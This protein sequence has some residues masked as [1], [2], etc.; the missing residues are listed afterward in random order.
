MRLLRVLQFG[1]ILFLATLVVSPHSCVAVGGSN[2]AG[3]S[4]RASGDRQVWNPP[5]HPLTIEDYYQHLDSRRIASLTGTFTQ[6]PYINPYAAT[7]IFER[8][9][10]FDTNTPP[11]IVEQALRDHGSVFMLDL[12]RD[13][14]RKVVY[15]PV[16]QYITMDWAPHARHLL[17]RYQLNSNVH[18]VRNWV[19]ANQIRPSPEYAPPILGGV[20]H[21]ASR[22]PIL[23][24]GTDTFDHMKA[25]ARAGSGKF[26]Y[27]QQGRSPVLVNPHTDNLFE[28][29]HAQDSTTVKGALRNYNTAKTSFGETLAGIIQGRP[30]YP[31]QDRESVLGRRKGPSI[32]QYP[33]FRMDASRTEM[34]N[35]LQRYGRFRVYS[36]DS[37]GH[38]SGFKVKLRNPEAQA[39]ESF[40]VSIKPLTA[41]EQKVEDS[42]A[43]MRRI[44][45]PI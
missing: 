31:I 26:W 7:P 6:Q 23:A 18:E 14:V 37:N 25:A 19:A 42:L 12:E 29:Y 35:A 36:V 15:D 11:Q 22:I 32:T 20:P 3:P 27:I 16:Q 1:L 43:A 33:R 2:D 17:Q 28:N 34:V 38:R 4:S 44:H 24:L 9:P 10:L 13:N 45:Y 8:A 41:A 30:I 21:D 5:R 39:T 40:V